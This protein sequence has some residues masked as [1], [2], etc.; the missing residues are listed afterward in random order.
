MRL[1]FKQLGT[2]NTPHRDLVGPHDE[3]VIRLARE[4]APSLD[5]AIVPTRGPAQFHPEPGAFLKV[6][7]T[8]VPDNAQLI[9]DKHIHPHCQPAALLEHGLHSFSMLGLCGWFLIGAS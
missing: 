7:R 8:D 4:V 2:V 6:H 3:A 5:A 1:L 9:A